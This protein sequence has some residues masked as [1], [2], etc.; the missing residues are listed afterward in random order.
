MFRSTFSPGAV[1]HVLVDDVLGEPVAGR[2]LAHA[3]DGPARDGSDAAENS[4][5]TSAATASAWGLMAAVCRLGSVG[6]DEQQARGLEEASGEE[7]RDDWSSGQHHS[8]DSRRGSWRQGL[9]DG[10]IIDMHVETL[11]D[12]TRL[13][14]VAKPGMGPGPHRVMSEGSERWRCAH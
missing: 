11:E 14:V 7:A 12:R 9:G 1:G 3:D 8:I 4:G 13:G 10:G 2:G 6:V 5:A